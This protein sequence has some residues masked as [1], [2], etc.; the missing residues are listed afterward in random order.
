MDSFGRAIAILLAVILVV[1][2]P[3]QYLAENQEAGLESH[4]K[5]ETRAFADDIM[6]NGYI[7]IE[8]YENFLDKLAET[9]QLY[10][11]DLIHSKQVDGSN[12]SSNNNSVYSAL[13]D[14]KGTYKNISLKRVLNKESDTKESI[15]STRQISTK[16]TE[17]ASIE[18]L[19]VHEHTDACY[20]GHRHGESGCTVDGNIYIGE[21]INTRNIRGKASPRLIQSDNFVS[22]GCGFNCSEC[23]QTLFSMG[24]L[25]YDYGIADISREKMDYHTF[26]TYY[27]NGDNQIGVK[28]RIIYQYLESSTPVDGWTRIASFMRG[29]VYRTFNPDWWTY[30]DLFND[31]KNAADSGNIPSSAILEKLKELGI[32]VPS[33]SCPYCMQKGIISKTLVKNWSCGKE[34]DTHPICDQVIT[35]ITAK[36]PT[37]IIRKGESI[38]TA[39]IASYLDGHTG[40]VSCSISGFDS[41]T[42]GN[43]TVTLTY[44]GLVDNAKTTGTKTCTVNVTV[45]PDKCPV[46]LTV[47]PSSYTVFNGSEPSYVVKVNYDDNTNSIIDSGYTKTGFTPGAGMKTVTFTYTENDTTVSTNIVITVKRNTKICEN[48]HTY[49]LDDFDSD[50]GCPICK[51]T[52][53]E[54]TAVPGKLT[55]QKGG[56]LDIRINAV[57]LDGHAEQVATGWKSDFDSNKLGK[58][59]V[60]VTYQDKTAP[61]EVTVTDNI[62]CP[63]C[64][65]EYPAGEDGRDGGCQVCKSTLVSITATPDTQTVKWGEPI[66][67]KVMATYQ[68]G[69]SSE[70][71]DWTSSFNSYQTGAQTVIVY[72]GNRSTAVTVTVISDREATCPVCQTV[73]DT[74]EHPN[75]CPVCAA[76]IVGIEASLQTGGKQVQFGN[77][78]NLYVVLVY[79]DG[80]KELA[81]SD[82][83]IEG[84]RPEE[85]GTQVIT[86]KYKE[87]TTTL[88]IEVIQSMAKKVCPN[89]HIYY[90]NEDGSDPGCPY[91]KQDISSDYSQS[92]LTCIYT[93]EILNELYKNE[94]YT[95]ENG[96]NI[97]IVV[98]EKSN[99]FSKL[100]NM[101]HNREDAKNEYSY[102]GVV[103]GE[104]V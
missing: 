83:S 66:D 80:H 39:V 15:V 44:S 55:V 68:D 37:Q 100:C 51:A 65:N 75:G 26:S 8:M 95:L 96:D 101:F 30:H 41:N 3:L 42:I 52:I 97:T 81:Y 35:K 84:F 82:W 87:F 99:L 85:L 91:C 23:G 50:G 63:V 78:L 60:T 25:T 12:V 104:H 10:N 46:G 32:Y 38:D 64:G 7:S 77:E 86:V 93:K 47:T 59:K 53:K 11:I 76:K 67:L 102:G 90:L 33:Y 72:Y 1:L 89:G 21:P 88:T 29:V 34:E 45:K 18:S 5:Y 79:R 4:I 57:Y 13:T 22:L 103:N 54:I 40:A 20:A 9:K 31:C 70:V 92:Y 19:A 94:I 98:T 17:E 28:Y 27:L 48:G 56:K 71:E 16:E 49:E 43:Q 61:V 69:H 58:Q 62:V 2:Y 74:V 73:Y 6:R 24:F 36:N 14:N